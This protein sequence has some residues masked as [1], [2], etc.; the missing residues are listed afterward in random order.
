VK[1]IAKFGFTPFHESRPVNGIAP[2]DMPLRAMCIFVRRRKRDTG[3]K[4]S[5]DKVAN[6][7]QADIKG[8]AGKEE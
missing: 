7:R 6:M 8:K 2:R 5:F 4:K 1:K 3:T